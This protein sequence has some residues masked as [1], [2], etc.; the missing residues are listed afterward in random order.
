M[1]MLNSAISR[2]ERRDAML[3]SRALAH[4]SLYLSFAPPSR[5][6]ESLSGDVF[7]FSSFS[8]YQLMQSFLMGD[9]ANVA[10]GH[11]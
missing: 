11:R 2:S 3:A 9:A 6:F 4:S 1:Q 8:K 5:T 7:F 10:Q